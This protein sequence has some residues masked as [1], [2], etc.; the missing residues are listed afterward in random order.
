[1]IPTK[2]CIHGVGFLDPCWECEERAQLRTAVKAPPHK[3][4]TWGFVLMT[5]SGKRVPR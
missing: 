2:R 5:A 3:R 1:M 4:P